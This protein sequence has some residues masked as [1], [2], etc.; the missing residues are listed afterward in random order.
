MVGRRVHIAVLLVAVL[1]VQV[2]V[3]DHDV[4]QSVFAIIHLVVL[5]RSDLFLVFGWVLDVQMVSMDVVLEDH[6]CS[7][8][9]LEASRQTDQKADEPIGRRAK[10]QTSQ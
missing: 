6:E 10:R 4:G 2:T 8:C 3:I 1:V 7:F 9:R 5:I